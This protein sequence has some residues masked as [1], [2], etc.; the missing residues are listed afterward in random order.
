MEL[1]KKPIDLY[2]HFNELDKGGFTAHYD[3][4]DFLNEKIIGSGDTLEEAEEDLNLQLERQRYLSQ[5]EMPDSIKGGENIT[6]ANSF[7]ITLSY[8]KFKKIFLQ[9]ATLARVQTDQE[10]KNY[11]KQ[12]IE[13]DGLQTLS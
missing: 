10:L 12:F 11:F 1:T 7:S 4:P 2:I 5:L 9:P 3:L 13:R 6:Y 8:R